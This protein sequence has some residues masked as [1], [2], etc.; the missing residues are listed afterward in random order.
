MKIILFGGT[1]NPIH[2]GHIHVALNA[3]KEIG[4]DKVIFIVNNKSKEKENILNVNER[5]NMA[6]L[7]IHDYS[8]FEISDFEMNNTDI[9]YTIDTVN[10]FKKKYSNDELFFLVGSD[11]FSNIESWKDYKELLQNINFIVYPRKNI[12]IKKLYNALLLNNEKFDISSS[13][14]REKNMW[15]LVPTIVNDYINDNGLYFMERYKM[16]NIS[17][18]RLQ[19]SLRVAK[20]CYNIMQKNNPELANVAWSAGVYHDVCKCESQEWLENKAYNQYGLKKAV[21]WK[22]LHGP[23]ASFYLVEKLKFSNN[24]ILNAIRRHTLPLDEAPFD[25]LTIIDKLLFCADKLE[26]NRTD[27]DVKNIKYFRD[28]LNQDINK[29]FI[30]LLEALKEQY[31]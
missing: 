9:S 27:E 28:L 20:L 19:H 5:F 29:C 7:A 26:I 31:K 2:N 16:F 25:Q 10:Y 17:D 18:S 6:K 3:L 21:S 11:Q 14:I 30:E 24:L 22:V 12:E 23:V 15:E 8:F 1:F 13:E 4:A